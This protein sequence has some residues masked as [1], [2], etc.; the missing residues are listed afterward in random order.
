MLLVVY[1]S[2]RG[3]RELEGLWKTAEGGRVLGTEMGFGL[4]LASCNGA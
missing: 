1:W 3:G 4:G 2:V